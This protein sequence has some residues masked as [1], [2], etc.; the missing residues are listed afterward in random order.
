MKH[1]LILVT[2]LFG[3][4]ACASVQPWFDVNALEPEMGAGGSGGEA[5]SGDGGDADAGD[6]GE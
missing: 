4:S 2:V 5:D 3:L 6:G 1:L